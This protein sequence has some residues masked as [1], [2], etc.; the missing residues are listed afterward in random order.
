VENGGG[1]NAYPAGRNVAT[2]KRVSEGEWKAHEEWVRQMSSVDENMRVQ[3]ERAEG[4]RRALM[5]DNEV[6]D[7]G[8]VDE[9]GEDSKDGDM[10]N[11][12]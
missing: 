8:T 10:Y 7:Q 5:W 9:V 12:A 11:C 4:W 1:F 2:A 3:R 6:V